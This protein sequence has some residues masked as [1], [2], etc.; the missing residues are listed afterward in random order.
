MKADVGRFEPVSRVGFTGFARSVCS[1]MLQNETSPS[2]WW[3]ASNPLH[4]REEPG[5]RWS[6]SHVASHADPQRLQ[7]LCAWHGRAAGGMVNESGH[8]PEV[9]KKSLQAMAADMGA[10]IPSSFWSE[11]G[12][13]ELRRLSPRE[14]EVSGV[15]SNRFMPAPST[16][17][18]ARS[19]GQRRWTCSSTGCDAP[20]R[21]GPSSFSGRSST[22]RH[23]SSSSSHGSTG[24]TT[25]TTAPTTATR[26]REWASRA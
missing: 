19:S 10:A 11:H 6:P 15:S 25:S 14:L 7:D 8:F 16:I 9:C 21:T 24:P 20:P 18:T 17:G 1:H 13:E 5:S 2:R 4:T 12:F 3:L 23:S 22:R 26:H